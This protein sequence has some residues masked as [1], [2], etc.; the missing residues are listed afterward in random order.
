MCSIMKKFAE[1]YFDSYVINKWNKIA[2]TLKYAKDGEYPTNMVKLLY[3]F[4][5]RSTRR[6]LSRNPENMEQAIII[7]NEMRNHEHYMFHNVNPVDIADINKIALK[8]L[9]I[10]RDR[11]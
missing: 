5:E 3:F 11:Q 1:Y 7:I 2:N 9:L 4:R 6:M 10:I 8:T